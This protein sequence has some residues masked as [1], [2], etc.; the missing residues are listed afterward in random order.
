MTEQGSGEYPIEEALPAQ[1]ALRDKA[2]LPTE[3]FP[4]GALLA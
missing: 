3:L 4:V 1:K 2:G